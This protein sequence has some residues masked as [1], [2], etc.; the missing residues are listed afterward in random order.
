MKNQFQP[1]DLI[2]YRKTKNGVHPGPRANNVH[3]APN[4]DT[5]NYTVD[6]YWLVQKVLDNGTLVAT[7]RRGKQN[8]LKADDPNLQKANWFQRVLHR[9]RFSELALPDQSSESLAAR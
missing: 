8:H 3:P 7:T 5:Y 6:K 4:G 1:G 2:I 9:S